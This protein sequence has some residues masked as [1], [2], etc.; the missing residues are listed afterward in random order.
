MLISPPSDSKVDAVELT[1]KGGV[2]N[3]AGHDPVSQT[4]PLAQPRASLELAQDQALQHDG[5]QQ[6][7]KW[8]SHRPSDLPPPEYTRSV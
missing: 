3:E 7:E 4:G 6:A 5:V 2:G 8:G 1:A